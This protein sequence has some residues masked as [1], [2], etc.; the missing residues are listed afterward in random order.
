MRGPSLLAVLLFTA[1]AA[2]RPCFAAL[3]S[4]HASAWAVL[5]EADTYDG[6]Y[7]DLPVGYV[8]STR[9]LDALIRLGWSPSH[10]LLMRDSDDR[11]QL[12]RA[13]DWL[14]TRVQPGDTALL[15]VAGEYQFFA[16]DLRWGSMLPGL[17]RRVPTSQRVLIV[18]TCYAGRLAEA[19]AGVTGEALPA[20]GRD[21]WDWWGLENRGRLIRGA[22]FTYFLARALERE[23]ED[24]P[25]SF[26]AAFA[27]AVAETQ[28][29][30]RTVIAHTPA[31][32]VP[33]HTI[34]QYPERLPVFPNPHL[35][36]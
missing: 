36:T 20:V 19:V 23:P 21:E 10:I 3:P 24:R 18:E 15:Y 34:G 17:W 33:F 1:V 25:I 2:S 7:P 22:P 27:A 6:Q 32:L 28:A 29:Y 9:L 14:A 5:I 26:A 4:P 11:D 16:H 8:N 35:V 31:A 12:A 30:F 13:V